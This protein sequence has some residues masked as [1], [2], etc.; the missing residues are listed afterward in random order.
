VF[1][2]GQTSTEYDNWIDGIKEVCIANDCKGGT[3]LKRYRIRFTVYSV[4]GAEF[5]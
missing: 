4:S 5:R 3:E 2:A 1:S